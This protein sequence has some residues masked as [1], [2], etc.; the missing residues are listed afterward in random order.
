MVYEIV[1]CKVVIQLLLLPYLIP[2]KGRYRNKNQH[3]KP[4]IS[5]CQDSII[6]HVKVS[7]V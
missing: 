3:W 2:P 1:D 7:A 5:E 4:S 6:I